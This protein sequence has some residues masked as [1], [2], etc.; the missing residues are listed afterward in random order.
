MGQRYD[1]GEEIVSTGYERRYAGLTP[2]QCD[3]E[4]ILLMQESVNGRRTWEDVA[5]RL[6]TLKRVKSYAPCPLDDCK[7][8]W[9]RVGVE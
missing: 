3:R 1:E 8:V 5:E 9:S 6:V 4:A 7:V 2:K